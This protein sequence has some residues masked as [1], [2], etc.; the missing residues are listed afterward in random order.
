RERNQRLRVLRERWKR[1]GR[2]K[3]SRGLCAPR[4]DRVALGSETVAV[5]VKAGGTVRVPPVH[6]N[7]LIS[8]GCSDP[9][10]AASVATGPAEGWSTDPG[11]PGCPTN[12]P[13]ASP[14]SL[15]EAAS[16]IDRLEATLSMATATRFP[17]SST[18]TRAS[19]RPHSRTRHC[20]S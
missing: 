3:R 10:E 17:A 7:R 13:E 6:V 20:D 14:V 4:A 18:Q 12:R 5:S 15:P 2:W 19:E 1:T 8:E 16:W 9:T 11:S